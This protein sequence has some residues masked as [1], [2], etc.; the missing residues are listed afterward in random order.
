MVA[1]HFSSG[2]DHADIVA[3]C[4]LE[5]RSELRA[6]AVARHD[7]NIVAGLPLRRREVIVGGSEE[8]EATIIAVDKDGGGR[9][10][11]HDQIAADFGGRGF[12]RRRKG[13]GTARSLSLISAPI[14]E[15]ER[16]D[17]ARPDVLVDPVFLAENVEPTVGLA[18]GL[19]LA[20]EE[21]ATRLRGEVEERYDPVLRLGRKIDQE[22]AARYQIDPRER[23]IGQHVLHGEDDRSAQVGRDPIAVALLRE[24]ALEPRERNLV[25]D[26]AR[27][28]TRARDGDRVFIDVGGEDLQL[29]VGSGLRERFMEEHRERIGLLAR[30]ASRNPDPYGTVR[31]DITDE[32][33]DDRRRQGREDVDITKETRDVDQQ[34]LG[35]QLKLQRIAAQVGRDNPRSRRAA[36]PSWPC[37]V[38]CDALGSPACRA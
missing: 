20:E 26:G 37:D 32:V 22:V 21:D 36:R 2:H 10:G 16:G 19:G 17:P 11:P 14:R 23:R 35:E 28:K 1:H 33:R 25:D 38:R 7:E 9:V 31:R 4:L 15:G 34:V 12:S 29:H 24:E 5:G 27:V 13:I 18:H 6:D 30:A 3:P 8:E